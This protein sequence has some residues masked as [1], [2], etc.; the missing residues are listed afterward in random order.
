MKLLNCFNGLVYLFF[1]SASSSGKTNP[2][3]ACQ[4]SGKLLGSLN[5]IRGN[6]RPLTYLLKSVRIG[7]MGRTNHQKD[8]HLFYQLF[9][10]FLSLLGSMANR[11]ITTSIRKTGIQRCEYKIR[12]FI[13]H[14]GL[15]KKD[16]FGQLWQL[17]NFLHTG[18]QKIS[19][20]PRMSEDTLC[21]W[22]PTHAKEYQ[23]LIILQF[24]GIFLDFLDDGTSR[25]HEIAS[26][27]PQSSFNLSTHAMGAYQTSRT[28]WKFLWR[29]DEHRT[30][31]PHLLGHRAIV[32]QFMQD[33]DRILNRSLGTQALKGLHCTPHPTAET[34][35]TRNSQFVIASHSSQLAILARLGRLG[36]LGMLKKHFLL[37]NLLPPPKSSSSGWSRGY[38]Q[39]AA[40]LLEFHAQ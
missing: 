40:R 34:Q 39:I 1:W 29:R 14:C 9:N 13:F 36:G 3:V 38:R 18:H 20:C 8:I 5:E 19:C 7:A 33:I 25:I 35:A 21:F 16:R 15:T 22:V 26:S 4:V 28:L 17:G 23:R 27:F 2:L 24:C 11:P 6:P 37:I 31:C 10:C 12:L 32:N 30:P